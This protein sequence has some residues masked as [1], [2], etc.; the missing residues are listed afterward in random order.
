[1]AIVWLERFGKLK[2]IK[3]LPIRICTRDI[4]AR[5]T[6]PQPTQLLLCPSEQLR[7]FQTVNVSNIVITGYNENEIIPVRFEVFTAVTMKNGVF[8]DVTPC[9][10]CKNRRFGG[11]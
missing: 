6:V 7:Y 3:F 9:G 8:W 10:S 5:S 11:T 1:V 2:K 4:P